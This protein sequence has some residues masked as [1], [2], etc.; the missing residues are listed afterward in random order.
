MEVTYNKIATIAKINDE[1]IERVKTERKVVQISYR[2]KQ[3]L[4]ENGQ[5]VFEPQM[6]TI[7]TS[8]IQY[9]IFYVS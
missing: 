9:I 7:V 3:T 4:K 1:I 5:P 6:I 8:C 2:L